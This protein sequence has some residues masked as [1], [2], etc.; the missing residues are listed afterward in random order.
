M[1]GLSM[2]AI[3]KI[4]KLDIWKKYKSFTDMGG[5]KAHMVCAIIKENPHLKGVC[6]D[7]VDCKTDAENHIKLN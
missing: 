2:G 1:N 3:I 5:S 7:L 6:A 4:P